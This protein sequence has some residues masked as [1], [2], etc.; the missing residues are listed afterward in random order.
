MWAN[1]WEIL[2]SLASISDRLSWLEK[3]SEKQDERQN[4][5]VN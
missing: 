4:D 5:L 3:Q 1:I 2:K